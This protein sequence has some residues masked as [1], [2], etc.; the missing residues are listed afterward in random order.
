EVLDVR[1]IEFTEQFAPR[2]PY[3]T[4]LVGQIARATVKLDR[5]EEMTLVDL[6]RCLDRAAFCWDSDRRAYV[7]N[8]G[9]RL[10]K[11]PARVAR[12]LERTKQG[13]DWL[14]ERW[15]GLGEVLHTN[16]AWDEPQRS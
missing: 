5:C 12:A 14:L 15:E 7:D 13:T 6:Q 1:I 8:L 2:T 9:A 10:S 16:G 4:W 3:E 11:D